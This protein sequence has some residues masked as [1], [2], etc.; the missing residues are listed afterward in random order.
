MNLMSETNNSAIHAIIYTV[1]LQKY[2]KPSL[3][4][5]KKG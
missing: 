5:L 1:I 3:P 4:I 2:K